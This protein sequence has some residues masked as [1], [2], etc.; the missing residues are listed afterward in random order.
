MQER[1]LII[2]KTEERGAR[3]EDRGAQTAKQQTHGGSGLKAAL[4]PNARLDY[5]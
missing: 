1:A 4:R 3:H 5:G 2:I